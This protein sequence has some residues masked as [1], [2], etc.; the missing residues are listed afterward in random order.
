MFPFMRKKRWSYDLANDKEIEAP[1]EDKS[2][3]QKR[4]SFKY[5][6]LNTWLSNDPKGS[7]TQSNDQLIEENK[8]ISKEKVLEKS[9]NEEENIGKEKDKEKVSEIEQSVETEIKIQS[10]SKSEEKSECVE[11]AQKPKMEK[12]NNADVSSDAKN[13]PRPS[14]LDEVLAETDSLNISSNALTEDEDVFKD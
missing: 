14:L 6:G 4:S 12:L 9:V 7:D 11:N 5:F 13:Q 3:L 1:D 8:E 2:S 10:E